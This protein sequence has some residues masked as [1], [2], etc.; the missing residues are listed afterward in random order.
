MVQEEAQ[1]RSSQSFEMNWL[2]AYSKR[3]P[4]KA[5]WQRR[6]VHIHWVQW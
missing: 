4:E 6:K 5:R 3:K 1:G 2:F